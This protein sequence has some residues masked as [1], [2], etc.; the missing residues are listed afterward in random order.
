[1]AILNKTPHIDKYFQQELSNIFFRGY[2]IE[3]TFRDLEGGILEVSCCI[4]E[5]LLMFISINKLKEF[6][7]RG[8]TFKNLSNFSNNLI[9]IYLNREDILDGNFPI[10]NESSYPICVGRLQGSNMGE[11][12]IL[13]NIQ[14]VPLNEPVFKGAYYGG[15]FN[16]VECIDN[17]TSLLKNT[18]KLEVKSILCDFQCA[19]ITESLLDNKELIETFKS[20]F[21]RFNELVFANKNKRKLGFDFVNNKIYGN[22]S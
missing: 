15:L 2:P 11:E 16:E 3:H 20:H 10:K 6:G 18:Q 22:L 5:S 12:V 9:C 7:Y 17:L 4:K 1:M 13:Q 8:I 19:G 14:L 21:G